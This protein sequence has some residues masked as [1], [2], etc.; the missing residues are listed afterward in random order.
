M[1]DRSPTKPRA[2]VVGAGIAGL[3]AAYRLEQAGW[4]VEVLEAEDHAG[5]RVETVRQGPY[6]VDTGATAI[7][8][9]YPLFLALAEELGTEVVWTSPYLGVVRDGRIRLFALDRLLQSGLRTDLLSP[10]TKLRLSRLVLDIVVN[11][12]RGRLQYDDL[13]RAE[14]LDTITA[15][16]YVRRLA[17]S[18]AD[19]YLAE[20]I[21]R[22]LLL[23][24]SHEVSRVELMSGLINA[25]AGK[26]STLAGG[27]AAV[28]DAL[29]GRLADVKVSTPVRR[30][31][32][33]EE[34]VRVTT[35]RG[36]HK[37]DGVVLACPLPVAL[38]VL[39]DPPSELVR[40]G[41]TLRF[42]K[43]INVAIGT[44]RRP[45]TPA[46]LIQLPRGEDREIAM[47]VLEHNKAPDRAPA[48][49][50]LTTVS[51]EMSSAR[52]WY[53]APDEELVGRSL[54]T[55][56]RVF[57]EVAGTVDMTFVRRWPIGLPHTRP[58]VYR[59]IGDLAGAID[60]AAPVQFAGDYLSQ[61][62]QNTAVAWGQRAAANLVAQQR[63][64]RPRTT[65]AP[66]AMA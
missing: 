23:A 66:A 31:E 62:G 49:H 9:R 15:K 26:L 8:A 17:G 44:T 50:G 2:V 5:G 25:V 33:T 20:P 39:D 21:T 38:E 36:V 28:V 58:G 37:A 27:Q 16:D 24:D 6:V 57:P 7:A 61:T 64:R 42:T 59:A 18:E 4:A 56:E 45:D 22:A 54:R 11:K 53:D 13:R 12:A 51:W 43:A 55:L 19:D 29:A 32:R 3:T 41:E 47:L 1:N 52:A 48:G 63:G 60:D 14:G 30:V 40:L 34:G 10:L 65:D 46:F 35:D